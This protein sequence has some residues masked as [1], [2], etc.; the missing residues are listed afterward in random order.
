MTL[1][2][3]VFSAYETPTNFVGWGLSALGVGQVDVWRALAA[4]GGDVDNKIFANEAN[5]F[6]DCTFHWEKNAL[7]PDDFNAPDYD[8]FILGTNAA[9]I[10]PLPSYDGLAALRVTCED[11]YSKTASAELALPAGKFCDGASQQFMAVGDDQK[12]IFPLQLMLIQGL[13]CNGQDLDQVHAPDIII[14]DEAEEAPPPQEIVITRETTTTKKKESSD[15]VLL[16]LVIA[17]AVVIFCCAVT[18]AGLVLKTKPGAWHHSSMCPVDS[19][20]D[21]VTIQLPAVENKNPVHADVNEGP[22]DEKK[23]PDDD[24]S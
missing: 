6:G 11:A 3:Y 8:D 14:L 12:A 24:D 4:T 7:W 13:P 1:S 16:G 22:P 5:N 21:V 23:R 9:L 10:A 17:F 15:G 2:T 20:D 18:L 19:S